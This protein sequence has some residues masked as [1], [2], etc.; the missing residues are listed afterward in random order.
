MPIGTCAHYKTLHKNFTGPLLDNH[1]QQIKRWY[2]LVMVS[3]RAKKY[4]NNV[5]HEC[6]TCSLTGVYMGVLQVHIV[7]HAGMC[8]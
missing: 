3:M 6:R 2:V 8:D 7:L 1:I 5:L 4:D